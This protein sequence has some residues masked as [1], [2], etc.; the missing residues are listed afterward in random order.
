MLYQKCLATSETFA[1]ADPGSVQKQGDVLETL[2]ALTD[3]AERAEQ[4][5][6][7][8]EWIKRTLHWLDRLDREKRLGRDVLEPSRLIAMGRQALYQPA[9]GGLGLDSTTAPAPDLPPLLQDWWKL[10]RGLGLARRGRHAQAAAEVRDVL[11]RDAQNPIKA[12]R[13]GRVFARCAEAVA[14]GKADTA[15]T[16]EER[17]LRQDYID[18]A[19]D[20][21][22]RTIRLSPDTTADTFAEPDYD[23]LWRRGDLAT[24]ARELSQEAS[25]K[26]PAP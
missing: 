24:V 1:D 5:P 15:L 9:M 6:E 16:A 8:L 17:T 4:F 3:N 23:L 10:L 14:L 20:A 26:A 25:R 11:S 21:V 22:W 7:S 13:V 19:L 12:I 2:E 18:S